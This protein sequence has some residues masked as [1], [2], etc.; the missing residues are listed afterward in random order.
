MVVLLS[1]QAVRRI[2]EVQRSIGFIHQIIGAIELLSL[3][4]VR[5]N[6]DLCFR[7]E[8][9]HAPYVASCGPR[10]A[11][12]T[13][14]TK[15]H[16]IRAWLRPFEWLC[17]CISAG[18]HENARALTRDPQV[19]VVCWDLGKQESSFVRP[20]RAFSPLVEASGYALQLGIRPY[21]LLESGVELLNVLRQ[22][23]HGESRD[24]HDQEKE[25][26]Y[27]DRGHGAAKTTASWKCIHVSSPRLFHRH[28]AIS[29]LIYATLLMNATCYTAALK[30]CSD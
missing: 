11:P 17:T 15:D 20:N 4:E 7:V 3:I 30:V 13:L 8:R 6:R 24:S 14:R 27:R 1:R 23:G 10:H 18:V 28:R 21:Q 9:L 22:C 29:L 19:D 16:S 25:P 26:V 5:Q 2:I 12:S